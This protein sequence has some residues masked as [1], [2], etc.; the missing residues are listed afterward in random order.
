LGFS[1]HTRAAKTLS[2]RFR[3]GS[4]RGQLPVERYLREGKGGFQLSAKWGEQKGQHVQRYS[5]IKGLRKA[6]R[7]P[8]LN[9]RA[10]AFLESERKKS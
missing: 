3:E 10:G 4:P 9:V 5:Q 7:V 2:N 8:I 1:T 6:G